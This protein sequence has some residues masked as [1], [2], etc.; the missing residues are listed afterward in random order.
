MWKFLVILQVKNGYCKSKFDFT[1][2]DF[3]MK[4]LKYGGPVTHN[5]L[6]QLLVKSGEKI[7]FQDTLCDDGLRI[8]IVNF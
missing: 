5:L 8:L 4:L 2:P 6:L 1:V 3:P 7:L